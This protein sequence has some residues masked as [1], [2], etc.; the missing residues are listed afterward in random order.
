MRKSSDMHLDWSEMDDVVARFFGDS[1]AIL[2]LGEWPETLGQKRLALYAVQGEDLLLETISQDWIDEEIA[3]P[4]RSAVFTGNGQ[5]F[6]KVSNTFH[7]HLTNLSIL[8][9]FVDE[10]E[11]KRAR[12][13]DGHV[14]K[15]G[16]V[17]ARVPALMV[18]EHGSVCFPVKLFSRK[19]V[20]F[21]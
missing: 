5:P 17:I 20:Y 1:Q 8:P 19:L 4:A 16:D 11:M 6:D 14:T 18:P 9:V 12:R 3:R 10:I 15:H 13:H 21:D 2:P 7:E